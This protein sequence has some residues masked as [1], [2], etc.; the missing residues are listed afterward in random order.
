ML[1]FKIVL[2]P[3]G[4][5]DVVGRDLTVVIGSGE[6]TLQTLDGDA[7]EATG[8]EGNDNDSVTATLVDVDDAGN[9]SPPS[10]AQ[11][12]LTDTIPPPA[13]EALGFV[14]TGET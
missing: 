6:P 2:P 13:P 7:L 10:T 8:F 3:P 9:H 1:Q 12:T 4:A 5:A 11:T 14:V